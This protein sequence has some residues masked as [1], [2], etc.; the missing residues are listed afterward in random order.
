LVDPV[1]VTGPLVEMMLPLSVSVDPVRE[2]AGLVAVLV[3]N[4]MPSVNALMVRVE[5]VR[6]ILPVAITVSVAVPPEF[7]AFTAQG[8]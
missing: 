5:P 6:V 8:T 3:A 4:T 2:M 7:V 1:R